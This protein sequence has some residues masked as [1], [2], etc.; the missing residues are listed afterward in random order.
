[1]T[2]TFPSIRLPSSVDWKLQGN[3]RTFRS[4]LDASVQTLEMSGL[5]WVGSVSW[6][7]LAATEFRLLQTFLARLHGAS[8]RFYFGPPQGYSPRGTASGVVK[9]NGASQTGTSLV[10]KDLTGTL[11]TGDF[12]SFDTTAGRELHIVT[13]DLNGSGTLA[14]D[15][16][17]RVSPADNAVVTYVGA[18]CVMGLASDEE[19]FISYRQGPFGSVTLAV[20]ER[21]T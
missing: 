14:I 21:F 10:V 1:M 6:G 3:T 2:I 8:G 17:I 9:V 5:A 4:P 11:L 15:P 20:V 7:T 12:I 16:P 19:G 13:A 18:T